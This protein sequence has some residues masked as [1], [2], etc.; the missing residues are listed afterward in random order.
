M[1]EEETILV[2]QT[3][4]DIQGHIV[5]ACLLLADEAADKETEW[6][7]VELV[8]DSESETANWVYNNPAWMEDLMTPGIEDFKRCHSEIPIQEVFDELYRI[9]HPAL[10]IAILRL[11]KG[12][13]TKYAIDKVSIDTTDTGLVQKAKP[14]KFKKESTKREKLADMSVVHGIR[15]MASE[16][17]TKEEIQKV[18]QKLLKKQPQPG[19]LSLNISMGRRGKDLQIPTAEQAQILQKAKEGG[20]E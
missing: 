9:A 5:S 11:S 12:D 19:T 14:R 16:G 3:A 13:Y 15:W 17:F 6:I 7:E 4:K 10:Q 8:N 2:K 1:N 20:E 18:C